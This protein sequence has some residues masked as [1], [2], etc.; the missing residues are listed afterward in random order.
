MGASL[1]RPLER[2]EPLSLRE[3]GTW[4]ESWPRPSLVGDLEQVALY[5]LTYMMRTGKKYTGL[6][7]QCLAHSP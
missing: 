3:G 7:G 5:S 4:V 6:L 1:P 2:T